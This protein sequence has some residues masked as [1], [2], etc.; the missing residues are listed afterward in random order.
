LVRALKIFGDET[1]AADYESWLSPVININALVP[2][3]GNTTV[4]EPQPEI[5]ATFPIGSLPSN[6]TTTPLPISN[7]TTPAPIN[8]GTVPVNSTSV[9]LP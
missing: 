3:S 4:P 5:N 6:E 8:N 1:N 2:A 7:V 9:A